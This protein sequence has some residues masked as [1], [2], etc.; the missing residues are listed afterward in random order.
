MPSLNGVDVL[1]VDDDADGREIA[2]TILE[3]CG[4]EAR[5]AGSASEAIEIIARDPPDVLLTDLEMPG[6]DGYTLL[7]QVRS[8]PSERSARM[9][10]AAFTAYASGQDRLK[11]LNAGF[12]LH[13]A[14]PAQP[15]E[16]AV[17]VARLA[18]MREAEEAPGQLS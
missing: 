18:Q 17:A 11:V 10:A 15:M 13:L 5:V 4:A 14:K 3:R 8:L 1:I 12:Q 16:L 9:P 7:R 6:E 2:A